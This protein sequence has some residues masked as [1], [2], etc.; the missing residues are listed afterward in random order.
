MTRLAAIASRD[1]ISGRDAFHAGP[2][3]GRMLR[4][5][6]EG[7][8]DACHALGVVYSTAPDATRDLVEAHKWFNLAATYGYEEAGVCR[9]DVALE[10]TAGQIAEAQRRARM[11]L[12]ASHRRA[13]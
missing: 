10:M 13:A 9:A 1:P 4:S 3:A 5:A 11:W 12:S 7:D 2:A 8:G 6:E